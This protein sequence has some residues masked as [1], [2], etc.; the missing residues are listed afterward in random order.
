MAGMVLLMCCGWTVLL[1]LSVQ[2]YENLALHKSAWQSS[3]VGSYTADLA[4]DGQYTDLAWNGGQCAMSGWRKTAEWR[5]DLLSRCTEYT[6]HRYTI[7]DGQQS[8]G[9]CMF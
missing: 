5:V 7:C 6:P 3:T 8:V 1:C 2:A 9:Y 4:V